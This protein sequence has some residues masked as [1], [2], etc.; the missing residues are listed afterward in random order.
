MQKDGKGK[1]NGEHSLNLATVILV[2]HYTKQRKEMGPE[3]RHK[4][5]KEKKIIKTDK[6]GNKKRD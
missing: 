5:K 3:K 1:Q 6:E 2:F 4:Q